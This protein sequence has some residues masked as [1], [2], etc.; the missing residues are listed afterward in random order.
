MGF[1]AQGIWNLEN[2][3]ICE[4]FWCIRGSYLELHGDSVEIPRTSENLAL[5]V[6]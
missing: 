4:G 6:V 2:S 3:G 1:R 5:F